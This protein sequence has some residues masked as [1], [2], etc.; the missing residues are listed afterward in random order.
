MGV[1]Y[2][3]G[4]ETPGVG[5]DCSGLT[6]AAFEV[7]GIGLPRVAQGQFDAGPRLPAGAGLRPGDL[8]F[9][10]GGP[11]DV[12]H[13]GL[14]L[15]V[16]DGR[17]VMVDAPHRGAVVR[18]EAFPTVVGAAWGADIYLGATRPAP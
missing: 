15:G 14:Y 9:F 17:P 2:V 6:Q 16:R 7:A 11:A 13:V 18:V 3:W 4:G 12:T 8:V 10:G 1:P 5:F